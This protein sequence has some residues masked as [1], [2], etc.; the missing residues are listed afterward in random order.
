MR[1]QKT[2]YIPAA[3]TCQSFSCL[4]REVHLIAFIHPRI[5]HVRP[6][7]SFNSFYGVGSRIDAHTGVGDYFLDSILSDL[8][9]LVLFAGVHPMY[10]DFI[11]C[12]RS[13]FRSVS[14][15][16][17]KMKIAILVACSEERVRFELPGS[18]SRCR[19]IQSWV[20][21]FAKAISIYP[22]WVR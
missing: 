11:G 6:G 8:D 17:W 7:N 15:N 10:S 2:P 1:K 13:D 18:S 14:I 21:S 3:Y 12:C 4:L 22:A 9:S 19:A 5:C 20:I 16:R